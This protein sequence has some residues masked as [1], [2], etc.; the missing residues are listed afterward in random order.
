MY[1][2][3]LFGMQHVQWHGKLW[4]DLFASRA[5]A[6]SSGCARYLWISF[7]RWANDKRMYYDSS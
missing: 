6:V 4:S 3:N 1:M 2:I 5:D 7:W